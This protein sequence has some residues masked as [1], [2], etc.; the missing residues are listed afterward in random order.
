M[1]ILEELI[2]YA[3]RCI[4]DIKISEDEDYITAT[5]VCGSLRSFGRRQQMRKRPW[6]TKKQ[7][8][9]SYLKIWIFM[10]FKKGDVNT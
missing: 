1:T 9:E 8:R 6:R 3:Q 10:E 5:V 2:Q 4:A 7:K